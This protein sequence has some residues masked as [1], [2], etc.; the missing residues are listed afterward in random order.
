[1]KGLKKLVSVLLG[2]V[3]LFSAAS[4]NFGGSTD[5]SSGEVVADMGMRETYQGTHDYTA[6]D[7]EEYLVKNGRTD[8]K[9]VV[10]AQT[11]EILERAKA[12]F[13]TLFREATGIKMTVVTDEGLE[14]NAT[15][16]YIS[17]GET[18]LTAATDIATEKAKLTRDGGRVLTK[19]KTVFIYGGSDYGT[20]FAV[21]TFMSITFNYECYFADCIEIDTR[22]K[23][24]ALKNY[25][26]TDIPDFKHRGAN[27]T[28]LRNEDGSISDYGYR[29]RYMDGRAFD[30]IPIHKTY[31]GVNDGRASTNSLAYLPIEIYE[32]EHP[33]CYSDNGDELCFTAH[34]DEVEFEWML[35]ECTNKIT[36]SLQRY[37]PEEY[38]L[39]NAASI[40]QQDHSGYCGCKEAGGCAELSLKYGGIV[41][42]YIAFCN[43]LAERVQDWMAQEENAAYARED[44]RIFFFGYQYTVEAPVKLDRNTGEYVP[45]HED[46]TMRDDVG[47]YLAMTNFD[48]QYSFWDD[49]NKQG[50]DNVEKWCALTDNIYY[51]LYSCN[52]RN[53][54]FPFESFNFYYDGAMSWLAN[55]SNVHYFSQ[56]QEPT[57]GTMTAWNNLKHYLDAKLAWDTSLNVETLVKN[58]FDAMYGQASEEMQDIFYSHRAYMNAVILEQYGLTGTGDSR[59]TL[60]KPEYWSFLQLEQW[61]KDLDAAKESLSHLKAVDPK[62]YELNC[63]HIEAEAI[64]NIY[65]TFICYKS[66]LT[67]T[68]KKE[69]KERLLYDIEWIG[70]QNMRIGH[71]SGSL[72]ETWVNNIEA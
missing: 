55:R 72:F 32:E 30:F 50:R 48:Y 9:L 54:M 2:A 36:Y 24:K 17:L 35:Q 45:Y 58:F 68:K 22:V 16:K 42:V 62:I 41:G 63:K 25:Q 71:N 19:D 27:N 13:I 12:E 6:T 18:R 14:H 51:W 44:F 3:T 52:F 28:L 1:M 57:K 8:Y 29:M 23:E 64:S 31:N 34:G 47:V 11:S 65:L 38:P 46:V 49:R 53:M 5:S 33:L 56:T 15:N 21:Y 37:T 20:L 39:Y 66:D 70:L 60:E 26:V 7:T 4:C 59:P 69:Y 67:S 10:P 43:K 40:T 61:I